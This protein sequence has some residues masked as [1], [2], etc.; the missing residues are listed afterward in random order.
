MNMVRLSVFLAVLMPQ[1][2]FAQAVQV[3]S[4]DHAGFARLVVYLPKNVEFSVENNAGETRIITSPVL[5]FDTSG[6]YD[7]IGRDRLSSVSQ[8]PDGG[9]LRLAYICECEVRTQTLSG[10]V[11]VV[12]L[13]GDRK[14]PELPEPV[15]ELAEPAPIPREIM[16]IPDAAIQPP[17]TSITMLE[18]REKTDALTRSLPDAADRTETAQADRLANL[19]RDLLEQIARAATQGLLEPGSSMSKAERAKRAD[20]PKAKDSAKPVKTDQTAEFDPGKEGGVRTETPLIKGQGHDSVERPVNS[21]GAACFDDQTLDL[22]AWQGDEP[23]THRLG[24]LRS[25]LT[26]EF[27]RPNTQA[28]IDLAKL[29]ISYGFG[30]EALGALNMAGDQTL[31]TAMIASMARIM[32]RGF[33]PEDS[34]FSHQI[35][36]DTHAAFWAT[37]SHKTLN[38]DLAP[39]LA[40]MLRTLNVLPL[41][42]RQYLGPILADRF[43]AMGDADSAQSIMRVVDRAGENHENGA[44][45]AKGKLLIEKGDLDAARESLHQVIGQNS[46]ISPDALI[47]LIEADLDAGL[48]VSAQT[49]ELVSAYALQFRNTPIEI[50]LLAIEILARAGAGQFD[51][52]FAS[53]RDKLP[54]DMDPAKRRKLRSRVAGL[55]VENAPPADF[56]RLGLS[57]SKD[58]PDRLEPETGNQIAQRFL[59]LGFPDIATAFVDTGADGPTGRER[60]FLRARIALAADRPRRAEAELVGL[61]GPEADRIRAR[62]RAEIG[63]HTAAKVFFEDLND[64][65]QAEKQ[66]WLGGQWAALSD[67]QD[68]L[69]SS[70]ATLMVDTV[71]PVDSDRAEGGEEIGELAQNRLLLQRTTASR[72]TL[73][74]LLSR[75]QVAIADDQ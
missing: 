26:G 14:T 21:F 31:E 28:A 70:V 65:P 3:R 11:L 68:S 71:E 67:S 16:P 43:I 36:C 23:F 74:T 62:S 24:V 5:D 50:E 44:D 35:D 7:R 25:D 18:S 17:V 72:D 40:A 30:V 52:A 15:K 38:G 69:T 39:E 63:D 57:L 47:A 13:V 20:R 37:L 60:R 45:L 34:P 51:A 56:L 1:M 55:M 33:D 29:Y 2:A 73:S 12:D 75:Y 27:D 58:R 46:E 54:D 10:N 64:Q 59:D 41:H 9:G 19:E 32:E 8:L 22:T 66:A 48:P 53:L 6:V 42:L 4:G 61:E 49:A